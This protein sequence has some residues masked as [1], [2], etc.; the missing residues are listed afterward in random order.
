MIAAPQ[1][2][3]VRNAKNETSLAMGALRFDETDPTLPIAKQDEVL[4]EDA[5][6]PRAGTGELG[7]GCDRMPIAAHQVAARRTWTNER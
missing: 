5:D 2:L 7:A 3:L 6:G 1:A 4:A